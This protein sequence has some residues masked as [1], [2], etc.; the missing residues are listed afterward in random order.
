MGI[1]VFSSWKSNFTPKVQT[2]GKSQT[3]VCKESKIFSLHI[4]GCLQ[5][6]QEEKMNGRP[7]V[8]HACEKHK[9]IQENWQ[10][11]KNCC[12]CCDLWAPHMNVRKLLPAAKQAN[13]PDLQFE[14]VVSLPIIKTLVET[15]VCL[16]FQKLGHPAARNPKPAGRHLPNG[17]SMPTTH[18]N[19]HKTTAQLCLSA[20][21]I[22]FP[23]R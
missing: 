1:L 20:L 18:R 17:P 12:N 13:F 6:A 5:Q 8:Q 23:D 9:Q 3:D 7:E 22:S 10:E 21:S 19:H 16:R 14:P 15:T 2:S 4:T 11:K